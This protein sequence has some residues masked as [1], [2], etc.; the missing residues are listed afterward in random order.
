MSLM[1]N[2]ISIH[3]LQLVRLYD[4]LNFTHQ[5]KEARK[6]YIHQHITVACYANNKYPII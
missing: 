1:Q 6:N 4:L 2:N 3:F 5:M